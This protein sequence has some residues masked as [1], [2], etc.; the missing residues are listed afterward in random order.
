MSKIVKGIVVKFYD[1]EGLLDG[2]TVIEIIEKEGS[3][4]CLINTLEGKRIQ[5]NEADIVPIK[6]QRVGK[7]SS[8]F[9]NKVKKAL[10]KENRELKKSL[11]PTVVSVK[12]KIKEEIS[13]SPTPLPVMKVSHPDEALFSELKE[14]K[15]RITELERRNEELSKNVCSAVSEDKYHKTI[16]AMRKSIICLTKEEDSEAMTSLLDLILELNDI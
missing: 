3:R 14:A 2:G 7:P 12:E 5:K 15:E 6:Y 16:V 9:L 10:I 8:T 1:N 13:D 11:I 4:I